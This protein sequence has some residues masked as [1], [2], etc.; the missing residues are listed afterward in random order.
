MPKGTETGTRR[1]AL[2]LGLD[3]L[4]PLNEPGE[5]SPSAARHVFLPVDHLTPNPFQ[6]RSSFD[7]QALAQL[8]ESIREM[9][10]I[11]PLIVRPTQTGSYQI[12]AGERRWR[13]ARMAGYT[14]VP[15]IIRDVSDSEALETALIENLQ[16]EDLN[17]LDTAEA[18]ET[19]INRFS[20]THEALAKRI[21]KDRSNITNYVRLLKLPDPIKEDV[22]NNLLS[23]GHARTLLSVESVSK[24]LHLSRQTVR[25]R[26]SVRELERIIQNFKQPKRNHQTKDVTDHSRVSGLEKGL[27]RLLST[28]VA[29]RQNANA[30]G[31]LEIYFHSGEELDRLLALLGYTEDFS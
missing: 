28:K 25:R 11:Q 8:S 15:V 16:R 6:P 9:G 30:S 20:Y 1:T 7:E 10:V 31:R 18:Y 26:L 23:M 4:I 3:A 21:G 14:T 27:S 17:P 13:A 19:L 29:V 24:Q 2:G 22:R 12:V 5:A